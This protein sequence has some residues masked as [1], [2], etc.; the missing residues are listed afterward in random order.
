MSYRCQKCGK[1]FDSSE[2]AHVANLY[3][4]PLYEGKYI[5]E[6]AVAE[7]CALESLGK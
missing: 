6:T 5:A 1:E 4:C 7:G 2:D 3:E